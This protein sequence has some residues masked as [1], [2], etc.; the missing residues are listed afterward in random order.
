MQ[1]S[2]YNV[3]TY[4]DGDE[5]EFIKLFNESYQHYA[6]V[7]SRTVDDWLWSCK[8]R[9]TVDSEGILVAEKNDEIVGYIVVGNLGEVYELCYNPAQNGWAIVSKL[10]ERAIQHVVAKGGG[11]LILLAPSDDAIICGICKKFEFKES[12]LSDVSVTTL[13]VLNFPMLIKKIVDRK[14]REKIDFE[15]TFLI[16]LKDAPPGDNLITVDTRG[17]LFLVKRGEID[18]PRIKICTD[19][20]TLTSLIFGELSVV[21]AILSLRLWVRPFRKLPKVLK[22]LSL[23]LLRETWYV[24]RWSTP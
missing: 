1:A 9:P 11:R 13:R 15:D 6:G 14:K 7:V 8:L 17:G 16:Q 24:P 18:N 23:L 3:R 20:R 12:Q 22:L 10:V 19:T 5:V 4:R 21:N 2:E